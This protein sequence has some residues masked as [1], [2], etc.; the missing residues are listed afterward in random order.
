MSGANSSRWCCNLLSKLDHER[1]LAIALSIDKTPTAQKGN[2]RLLSH[3]SI[4]FAFRS[5]FKRGSRSID[6]TRR[7]QKNRLT[8]TKWSPRTQILFSVM[9]TNRNECFCAKKT[10][11][12]GATA[13]YQGCHWITKAAISAFCLPFWEK[14]DRSTQID[15]SLIIAEEYLHK[16]LMEVEL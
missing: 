12:K 8:N 6:D 5:S 14:P 16:R 3:L 2:Q 13:H 1:D 11:E 10:K 7:Q 4:L 9:K 15:L